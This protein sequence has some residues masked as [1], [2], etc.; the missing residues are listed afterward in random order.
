LAP[1]QST[2]F[3]GISLGELTSYEGGA[4]LIIAGHELEGKVVN[5]DKPLAVL[6]KDCSSVDGNVVSW[7]VVGLVRRKFLFVTKPKATITK[8]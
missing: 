2:L 7:K 1:K 5:L 6:C 3:D 4:S 8:N